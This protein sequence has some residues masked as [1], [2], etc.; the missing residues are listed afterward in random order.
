MTVRCYATMPWLIREA[1]CPPDAAYCAARRAAAY[2]PLPAR[3]P[4][5]KTAGLLFD[6]DEAAA[7]L[8]GQQGR[9]AGDGWMAGQPWHAGGKDV[10]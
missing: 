6:A 2:D 1:G 7:W 8:E 4:A 5:N 3:M 10:H 9:Y